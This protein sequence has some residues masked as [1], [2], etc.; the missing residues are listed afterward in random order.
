MAD[1]FIDYE[2]SDSGVAREIAT[3]LALPSRAE[4]RP[5]T[6]LARVEQ[7]QR[8]GRVVL[9]AGDGVNDSPALRAADVGVA[10]GSGTAVARGCSPVELAGDDLRALAVL[11]AGSRRLAT[12]AR[13]SVA[14]TLTYNS[15][16]LVAAACGL[17]HPLVAV[18]AM[19]ASS[20]AVAVRSWRL[21][22]W[23]P[24]SGTAAS[25]APAE[26]EPLGGMS[27]AQTRPSPSVSGAPA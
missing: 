18:A 23:S 6:K 21:L 9:V 8:Q 2:P 5:E 13:G 27:R 24:A 12:V 3:E 14:W 25:S 1:V 22:E 19:I 11:V 17:L 15:V 7:L 4:A 26:A 20:L 10:L 16:A